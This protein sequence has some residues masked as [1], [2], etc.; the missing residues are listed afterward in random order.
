MAERTLDDET[1]AKRARDRDLPPPSW[2]RRMLPGRALAGLVRPRGR[3]A[4]DSLVAL[5]YAVPQLVLY[6]GLQLLP[7]LIA[8]PIMFT[9]RI[10]FLDTDVSAVGLANLWSLFEQ[11]L[12]PVFLEALRRTVI[13]TLVNYVVVIVLGFLLALAMFELTSRF[14]GMFFTIIYMPWMISGVGVGLMMIML[15]SKDTGSANLLLEE[16]GAPRNL[17]DARSEGAAIYALPFIYGWKTAGF[18]MALF[19]GGL[20]SIP[21]ETIE[22]ARMDGASYVQRVVHVYL[23]QIVPS[24]VIVT[25][26]TIINSFGIFDELVGLGA[27]GGNRNAQ[28]MSVFIYELGFGGAANTGARTGTL[29]QAITASLLV[30]MPLVVAAFFLNRLQRRLQYN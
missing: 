5:G 6:V 14:K 9:D 8:L 13:F 19:L 3:A 15:F 21:K 7:F 4:R 20:L 29:A 12:R 1:V 24:V 23:P 11:P 25:I 26:F 28:F 22:S 2:G 17:L 18:N 30:F 10:D 16:V 27:L